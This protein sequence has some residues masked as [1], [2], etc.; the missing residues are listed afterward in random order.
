MKTLHS[1]MLFLTLVL[2]SVRPSWPQAQPFLLVK[3]VNEFDQPMRYINFRIA[4]VGNYSSDP[5]GECR[6]NLP[7]DKGPGQPIEFELK[8]DSL[9]IFEPANGR[10]KV[11]DRDPIVL[12]L[13]PKGDHRLLNREEMKALMN[14]LISEATRKEIQR[15]QAEKAKLEQQLA[16][17]PP[18]PLAEEAQRL[19]FNKE[20]LL[21]AI[22]KVKQ[23][24]QESEDPFEVG[25]ANL[26][27]K[28]YHKAA[29]L[30]EKAIAAGEKKIREGKR[31]EEL[32]PEKYMTL[33]NARA[34]EHKL[35]EAVAAYEKAIRLRPSYG[36]AYLLLGN[37]LD[38][39][40][41]LKG[42]MKNFKKA[43]SIYRGESLGLPTQNEAAALGNLG[44]VFSGLGEPD[45]ARVSHQ[46]ALIIDRK[47]GYR[48][49]EANQ[50]GNL[51]LVFYD[52]GRFDSAAVYFQVVLK[53]HREF[54]YRD[55]E[56]KDLGNLG[57]VFHDLGQLDSAAVYFQAAFKIAREIGYRQGEAIH[58]GNLGLVF[59]ALGQPDSAAVC[60]QA[61]LK[62]NREIGY[63][64]G[65]ANNLDGLGLVFS[66]LGELDS[67]RVYHQAALKIARQTGYRQGE[68]A[69]LGNLGLVFSDLGKPD[70]ARVYHQASLKIAREIGARLNEAAQL[71]NLSVVFHDR[72]QPDSARVYHQAALK[73]A[74]EIG[75]RHGEAHNLSHLGVLWKELGQFDQARQYLKQ[76]LKILKEIGS[77]YQQWVLYQLDEVNSLANQRWFDTGDAQAEKGELDSA[78]VYY[79]LALQDSRNN[80][81]RQGEL[82][83]LGS[84]SFL[85]HEQQFNFPQ[86]FAIDQQR[87]QLDSANISVQADFAE[88]HFTSGQFRAC[89][90]RLVALLVNSEIKQSTKIALRPIQIANALALDQAEK[91][92]AKLDTLQATIASQPDTFK[93]SWTFNGTK[94]FISTNEKLAPYREWLLQLFQALEIKEGREAMLAALR[95][96]RANFQVVDKK[97]R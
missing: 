37:V 71:G 31:E 21:A 2:S 94:H 85:F 53:I 78:K 82:L 83:A 16:S 63:R 36:G 90:K 32:L 25:L 87:Q 1:G 68:A 58:L 44:L 18:D 61:A 84:L 9:A 13:L 33:G 43:L 6:I 8:N 88:K 80:S 4:F 56:A 20:E 50:L 22:E 14:K 23:Q 48:Q 91:I 29:Q 39:M 97:V 69:H 19:G 89:E 81:Y 12:K 96:V 30:I 35:K 76:S 24:L 5:N 27:E 3:V 10:D 52:L 59:N 46:A 65:E 64:Q 45:S 42:A 17:A 41:D 70:S 92:P 40:G 73:I 75:Y 72:S 38:V 51:G 47:I 74:R 62:I 49:G 66:D 67:A 77:P 26:Y 57:M 7:A 79:N 55:G 86:A 11:P 28:R 54:G 95:E 93:V 60:L 15:L 34:G